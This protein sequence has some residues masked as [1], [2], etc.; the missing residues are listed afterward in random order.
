V[1]ESNATWLDTPQGPMTVRQISGAIAR[2]IVCEAKP[3]MRLVKGEKFGMIRFG[4]RVELY[5]PLNA[6]IRVSNGQKVYS[7]T[8]VVAQFK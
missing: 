8:S 5:L 2:H 4:S 3:G 7:G 1:N 6:E